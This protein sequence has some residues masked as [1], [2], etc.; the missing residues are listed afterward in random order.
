MESAGGLGGHHGWLWS[1][2][3]MLLILQE[4]HNWL[5]ASHEDGATASTDVSDNEQ[6][7]IIDDDDSACWQFG[8]DVH[9][10]KG[11][12]M[13]VYFDADEIQTGPD[14]V[15]YDISYLGFLLRGA[16]SCRL[17]LLGSSVVLV[18]CVCL[19]RLRSRRNGA[20]ADPRSECRRIMPGVG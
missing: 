18:F 8:T 3:C 2:C 12:A 1:C 9:Q 6:L 17:G 20:G 15:L 13:Q 5:Q 10:W 7:A 16:R 11:H 4:T 19:Q 14:G